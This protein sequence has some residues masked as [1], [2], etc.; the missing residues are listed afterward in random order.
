MGSSNGWTPCP[1]RLQTYKRKGTHKRGTAQLRGNSSAVVSRSPRHTGPR[2]PQLGNGG[3]P[4]N[5]QPGLAE[6]EERTRL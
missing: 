6:G 1:W 5:F 2:T 4:L 3:S